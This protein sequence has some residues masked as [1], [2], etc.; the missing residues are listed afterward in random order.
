MAHA[1][2]KGAI[3]FGLVTIPCSLYPATNR[4]ELAFHMLD[5]RDFEPIHQ[6]RKNAAGEAV[7]W[8]EVVKGY[9]YAE[10]Q[11]VVLTDEDLRQANVEATRTLDIMQFVD[12]SAIDHIFCDTPYYLEP[13]KQGRKAYALLR[14][15]L[16]REGK[17]GLAKVV[18]RTRQHLAA[19][20]PEGRVLVA[21]VL[22]WAHEIRD[23][24]VLDLPSENL[25]ELGVSPQEI[26]MAAQLVTAMV[27]DWDPAQY[28]DTYRE[29]ILRMIDEKVKS[30]QTRVLTQEAPAEGEQ[31]AGGQ[32]VDIMALLKRSVEQQKEQEAQPVASSPG[33]R[34]TAKGA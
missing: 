9:E 21:Q 20:R 27:A 19:V 30:G 10:G 3:S 11:W 4:S 22:R 5:K 8:E 25:D 16:R 7:P 2:W 24:G 12:D 6:E 33:R 28:K 13:T 14:D 31:P 18:I 15:T 17:V 26:D 34:K 1:L 32:V 29:D 23:A